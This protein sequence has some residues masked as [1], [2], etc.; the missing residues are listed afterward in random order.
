[1]RSTGYYHFI[2]LTSKFPVPEAHVCEVRHD[3]AVALSAARRSVRDFRQLQLLGFQSS[4]DRRNPRQIQALAQA[5]QP[6]LLTNSSS[7]SAPALPNPSVPAGRSPAQRTWPSNLRLGVFSD[8][9]RQMRGSALMAARLSQQ[10][11]PTGKS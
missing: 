10:N 11:R 2:N 4:K 7:L 9:Y 5:S 8:T 1:V 3:P 6:A